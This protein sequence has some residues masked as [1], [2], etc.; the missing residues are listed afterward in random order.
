M[1]NIQLEL[2]QTLAVCE[3]VVYQE[4][5]ELRSVLAGFLLSFMIVQRSIRKR[6]IRDSVIIMYRK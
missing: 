1:Y 2:S 5:L 3:V 6:D 4:H